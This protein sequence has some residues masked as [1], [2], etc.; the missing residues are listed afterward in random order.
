MNERNSV[1]PEHL[2]W[3]AKQANERGR[4]WILF[5]DDAAPAG[6]TSVARDPAR[7]IVLDAMR[8]CRVAGV[9]PKF[10]RENPAHYWRGSR[11]MQRAV[12]VCSISTSPATA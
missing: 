10:L 2:A 8:A 9:T 3:I 11:D 1:H 12:V 7:R 5:D 6:N 4:F